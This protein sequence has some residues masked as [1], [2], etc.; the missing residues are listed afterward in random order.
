MEPGNEAGGAPAATVQ[1]AEPDAKPN[2]GLAIVAGIAVA[3]LGAVLWAFVTV[4]SGYELGLMAIAIGFLVGQ[5][6]R[7][8]GKGT[9]KRFGYLG[10]VCALAGCLLGN[11]LSAIAF[12]AKAQGLDLM[13]VIGILDPDLSQKLMTATFSAMDLL[14]YAIAIYEGFKFSTEQRAQ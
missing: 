6:I 1:H 14:F 10:A 2:F 12:F 4:V 3:V 5:A 8:A 7:F 9:D 11:Y 13:Q